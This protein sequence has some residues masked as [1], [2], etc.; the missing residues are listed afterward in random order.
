M[1]WCL[2]ES[3][4]LADATEVICSLPRE[5]KAHIYR[6]GILNIMYWSAF[7]LTLDL[8]AYFRSAE[9]DWVQLYMEEK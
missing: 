5:S 6:I 4:R 3:G 9:V 8:L 1:P 2:L 7:D